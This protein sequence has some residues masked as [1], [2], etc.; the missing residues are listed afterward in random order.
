MAQA[1]STLRG[2]RSRLGLSQVECAIALGVPVETF[3]A[4]DAGRRRPPE[5]IVSQ[6]RT[7]KGKRPPHERVPL[8]TLAH[9]F[10]VHVRTLRAAARDGLTTRG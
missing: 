2:I 1:A 8:Q 3:R 7:L 4:W 9:D 10:H 6:A 5:A